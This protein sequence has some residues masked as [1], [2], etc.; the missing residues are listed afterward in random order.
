[1]NF[2]GPVRRYIKSQRQRRLR[3]GIL[4]GTLRNPTFSKLDD[5]ISFHFENWSNPDHINKAGMTV[6]LRS[7]CEQPALI[8][9]T[10]SSAWGTN[11][12]RL[13]A[14]YV[15]SFGGKFE[16]VDIRDEPRSTLLDLEDVSEIHI[17]D[18]VDF[19]WNYKL[20]AGFTQ[21]NLAY[22]D[23]WDL[24]LSD[25]SASMEHGLAEWQALLP[26]LGPGS[27]VVI[28]DTPIDPQLL[29]ADGVEFAI[30]NGF[31]P[32][33]GALVLAGL[34]T[35]KDFQVIYHHYNVV[36]LHK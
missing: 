31:T 1:M 21:V 27:I 35:W 10:G 23:S 5:L 19:L 36:L 18:S 11:S 14:S 7:L 3:D 2:S 9:E 17:G 34:D 16:T 30:S 25:P 33:K 29:G 6:G 8:L 32:G 22:L 26:L 12:S 20:P 13:W 28:D 15:R 24:D 4:R